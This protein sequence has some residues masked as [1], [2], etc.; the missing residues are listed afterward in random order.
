[1]NNNPTMEKPVKRRP[2]KFLRRLA[3]GAL[4]CV[5]VGGL[6]FL[7]GR[8]SAGK[9]LEEPQLSAV[10]LES[11]LTQAQELATVTY[12]YTNMAQFQSSS[13]FY[14][15]TLPFTT[16]KFILTYDGIIKAGV[17]LQNASVSVAGTAVT[18]ALPAAEILSHEIEEDSVEIFDEK[19]SLFN[20]FTVEDFTAFQA[21]Q[22]QAMEARALERGLLDEARTQ[23]ESGIRALL[24]PLVPEGY[25]LTVRSS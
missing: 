3:T 9:E 23:A 2:L 25:S 17:N 10:V 20:P 19:A 24:S 18:V 6:C 22:K 12:A 8:L 4:L 5:L 7:G 1:M 13:S 15:V 21:D 14:G 16:K 11:R